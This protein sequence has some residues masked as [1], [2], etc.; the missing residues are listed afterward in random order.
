[1]GI[2]NETFKIYQWLGR[3]Y[4][5]LGEVYL[6]QKDRRNVRSYLLKARDIFK[7]LKAKKDL[8]RTEN[9]LRLLISNNISPQSS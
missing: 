2:Y 7:K 6:D 5:D 4:R 1:L 3:S 8:E 9:L